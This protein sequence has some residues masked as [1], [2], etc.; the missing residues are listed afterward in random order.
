MSTTKILFICRGGVFRSR[1]AQA[2][3][4]SVLTARKDS[5]TEVISSGIEADEDASITISPWATR[6]L[7]RAKLSQ[8][9]QVEKLQTTQKL[10]DDSTTLVFL[11][12][13]IYRD[14]RTRFEIAPDK[15]RVWLVPDIEET[16]ADEYEIF[17]KIK[18]SVD[19]LLS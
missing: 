1:L 7:E 8:F 15:T 16:E 9:V 12:Q 2:Y 11:N 4:V 6:V 13:D 18:Q 17:E 14:A 5:S 3:A 10:I 19:Y